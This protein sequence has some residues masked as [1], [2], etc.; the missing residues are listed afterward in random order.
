MIYWLSPVPPEQSNSGGTRKLGDLSCLLQGAGIDSCVAGLRDLGYIK[1]QAGDVVVVPEIFGHGLDTLIPRGV[2][3]VSFVQNGYLIDLGIDLA[4]PHPFL[5]TP[6]LLAVMVESQHSADL[7]RLRVPDLKVPIIPTHSSGN[8]RMGCDAEFR[9]GA[10]PR[11]KR[12]AF[13][14]YKHA[15]QNAAI[16]DNLPLPDGWAT[17]QLTGTD[18]EVATGLRSAAIFAAPN[19]IEGLCAPTQEAMISGC[20]VVAWPGGPSLFAHHPTPDW[21]YAV[22]AADK[23]AG[24]PMEYLR[25]RA[26]MVP[27]DDVEGFRAALIRTAAHIDRD[28]EPWATKTLKWSRWHCKTYSR[29]REKDEVVEIMAGLTSAV[30]A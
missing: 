27:Q 15:G 24:G 21:S 12:V 7:V 5:D 25:G 30:P 16:F 8:G 2:K 19:S 26:V 1:W 17:V 20:V 22:A 10:W 11:E 23:W 18:A 9:Y 6:D 13:F 3:R 28:P 4:R 29:Q 14:G